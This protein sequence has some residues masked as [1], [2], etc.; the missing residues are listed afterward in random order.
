MKL[1]KLFFAVVFFC[2]LQAMAQKDLFQNQLN[3]YKTAIQYNDYNVAANALYQALALKPNRTDLKDTLCLVYF[4]AQNYVQAYLLSSEILKN[5]EN[6]TTILEIAATSKKNLG[7]TKEAL[8]DFDKL[9]RLKPQL[10][11]LYQI[12]TMQ[13]QLKR[14]GECLVTLDKIITAPD[15]E[16]ET[17]SISVGNEVQKVPYKAAALNIKGI[18]ALELDK[19]DE[20]KLL[21][22]EALKVY[23]EFVLAKNNLQAIS[24]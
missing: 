17:A 20:A 16:K 8:D 7:L 15:A 21:F 18:V 6:N 23:P 19:K 24:K 1:K 11:Y 10:Y 5:N 12:A 14:V 22:T 4:S 2:G 9:N 3:I 13:F